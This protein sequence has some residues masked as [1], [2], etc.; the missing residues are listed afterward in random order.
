MRERNRRGRD[1]GREREREGKM[2][3]IPMV[4]TGEGNQ[5]KPIN[6]GANITQ[7]D[8]SALVSVILRGKLFHSTLSR[9]PK[10]LLGHCGT[11]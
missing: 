4:C 7:I 11:F 1:G 10:L 9:G 6:P 2:S 8:P 5:A 3:Q